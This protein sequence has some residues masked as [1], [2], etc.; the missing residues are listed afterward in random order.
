MTAWPRGLAAA[1]LL[2]ASAC[3]LAEPRAAGIAPSPQATVTDAQ[4]GLVW[5]RCSIGQQY[6]QGRCLG[7]AE[8]VSWSEAQ[9]RVDALATAACPWRLP[10]FHEMRGLMQ[11]PGEASGQA[12]MAIDADLFPDTPAGWYW[13]Q[14]SAG[15]HSQQDCFV[16]FAGEGRTRCNMGG[17]FHLRLVML[18]EQAEG[19]LRRD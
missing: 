19:C 7:E 13:N 9:A 15:G 12:P 14:A 18:A 3:G 4:K 11:P 17:Q 8:R 6:E 1:L 16:D 2:V 5:M 10:R